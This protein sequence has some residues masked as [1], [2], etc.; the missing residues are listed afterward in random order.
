MNCYYQDLAKYNLKVQ[1]RTTLK[2]CIGLISRL[3]IYNSYVCAV[4]RRRGASIGVNSIINYKLAK[5]ANKNL[6]IGDDTIVDTDSIDL[7]APVTIGSH[8]IIN[9][10]VDI[11]RVSHKIDD[12]TEF[13]TRPYPMLVIEDYCWLA[14][15]SIV[16]PSVTSIARGSVLGAYS[17]TSKN[18]VSMGIYVGNPSQMIRTHNTIYNELVV[19]S[20]K[21]GDLK[22]FIN[23]LKSK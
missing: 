20:L 15:G 10:G 6:I 4:A 9:K 12:D 16:L 7:R 8:C 3:Y 13:T 23:A 1:Q 19:C 17:V 5:K 14:T 18:T 22:Y 2:K 21:G 11:I